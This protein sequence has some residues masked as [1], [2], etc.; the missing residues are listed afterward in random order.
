MTTRENFLPLSGNASPALSDTGT[1]EAFAHHAPGANW[2]RPVE[3][4]NQF[5][6]ASAEALL[7]GPADRYSVGDLLMPH[8]LTRLLN[9]SRLRC[10]GLVSSDF[11][12]VGGH[13]VRNYGESAIEMGGEHLNLIHA[14]G[15]TLSQDLISGYSEAATE[16]EADRFSSLVRIG[17]Q[18]VLKQYVQRRSGQVDDFAYVL[19]SE[20]QFMGAKSCFHAVGLSD[21]ESLSAEMQERLVEILKTAGFVGVRDRKG[22]DFLEKRGV[23]VDRMP[24]GL[25]VL[26]QVCERQLMGKADADSIKEVRKKFRKGWIAVE[27]GRIAES[28]RER[29]AEAL[30]EVAR[31]ERLGIV[32]FDGVDSSENEAPDFRLNWLKAFPI[33]KAMFFGSG[34][35]WEVANLIIQS[36]LFCGSSLNCRSIAMSSAVPRI[37]VPSGTDVASSYCSL[38]EYHAVPVEFDYEGDWSEQLSAALH[39]D[40][41]ALKRHANDLHDSYFTAFSRMC[42]VMELS[43]KL[44]PS[45]A[46]TEHPR[47]AEVTRQ[48]AGDWFSDAKGISLFRNLSRKRN[49]RAARR[50]ASAVQKEEKETIA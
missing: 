48:V 34:N 29:I 16:E 7:I 27:I 4:I 44:L 14:G 6:V 1:E 32:L 21:P 17:E 36:R 13:A 30:M 2:A 50:A 8:V 24:C 47:L 45:R 3:E 31:I 33:G 38:W 40:S 43:A 26:P 19:A 25:S 9:L 5:G 39:V 15:E 28:D 46:R 11:T 23:N 37:N 49:R 10:A 35:I 41:A 18:S 42:R 12:H 22:A 20:G